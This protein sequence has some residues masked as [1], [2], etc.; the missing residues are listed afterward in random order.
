MKSLIHRL[1][2]LLFVFAFISFCSSAQTDDDKSK[3]KTYYQIYLKQPAKKIKLLMDDKKLL[4]VQ[5]IIS[6]DK[7]SIILKNYE[8]GTK[9]RV[10]VVYEDGKEDEF[11]KT[12]CYIDPV[13]L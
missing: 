10:V 6:D 4:P 7:K 2:P 12:P 1:V 13:V 3:P 11:I 9:V 8:K 5:G